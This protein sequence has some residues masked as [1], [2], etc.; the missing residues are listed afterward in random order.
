MRCN[1]CNAQI[2]DGSTFCPACGTQLS[3]NPLG[4]DATRIAQ[5]SAPPSRPPSTPPSTPV[6]QPYQQRAYP[7]QQPYYAPAPKEKSN[8][9]LWVVVGVLAAALLGLGGWLLVDTLN[10]NG[11]ATQPAKD[12]QVVQV[13]SAVDKQ[14]AQ[15]SQTSSQSSQT[16]SQQS[17]SSAT[18]E[19]AQPESQP[20]VVPAP[21]QTSPRPSATSERVVLKGKLNGDNVTFTLFS[22]GSDYYIGSFQNHKVGVTWSVEGYLYPGSVELRSTGLKKDWNFYAAGDPDHLSGR[23]TNGTVTYDMQ[24]HYE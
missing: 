10:G 13:T 12:A 2:P 5:P 7:P 1:R 15:Q 23:S 3:N 21:Q 18:E 9:A 16:S 11:D 17:S 19:V 20:Q 8:T 22:Q 14:K 6:G 24:L 4:D